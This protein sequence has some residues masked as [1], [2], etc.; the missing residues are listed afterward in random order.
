MR[1]AEKEFLNN[2]LKLL[3]RNTRKKLKIEFKKNHHR[4]QKINHRCAIFF[5]I[6]ENILFLLENC[7]HHSHYHVEEITTC[8]L[9]TIQYTIKNYTLPNNIFFVCWNLTPIIQKACT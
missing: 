7:I 6:T 2:Y 9:N 3:H 1:F 5:C 4:H 8:I